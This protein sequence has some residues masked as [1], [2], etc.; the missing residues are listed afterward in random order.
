VKLAIASDH[1]GYELKNSLI[2]F[3]K[4]KDIEVE[5]LGNQGTES[6][7]YPDYAVQVAKRVSE[8]KVENGVLICGTGIGMSITANKFKNVRAAVVTDEFTAKMSK[9]HN[10]ANVLCLGGRVRQPEEAKKLVGIWLETRFEGGRHSRRL[11]KI[12]EIEKKNMK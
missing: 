9:E 12:G 11:A 3:L 2:E 5:D 8:G 10:N 6:V 7:D 1:G 4:K